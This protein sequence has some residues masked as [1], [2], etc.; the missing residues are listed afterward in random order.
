MNKE[1]ENFKHLLEYFV[2]H[3]KNETYKL[4]TENYQ[5]YDVLEI[6]L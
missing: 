4:I 3:L 1:I 5:E 6:R 2:C